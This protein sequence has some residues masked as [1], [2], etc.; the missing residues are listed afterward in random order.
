MLVRQ[1]ITRE[2]LRKE[3]PMRKISAMAVALALFPTPFKEIYYV[4]TSD[5]RKAT[6]LEQPQLVLTKAIRA[7]L[8][9]NDFYYSCRTAE[10]RWAI[11]WQPSGHIH[12]VNTIFSRTV[13]LQERITRNE[14]KRN[15]RA[16]RIAKILSLYGNKIIFHK[17]KSIESAKVKRTPHGAYALK[18]QIKKDKKRFR[19]KDS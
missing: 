13:N 8:G 6:T 17:A 9:T 14:L 11:K 1:I 4:P 7:F 10:E 15:A 16:R 3:L 5:E 2:D 12:V 19:E 18:S